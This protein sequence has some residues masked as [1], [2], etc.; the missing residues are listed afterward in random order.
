M[1]WLANRQRYT[2]TV[3]DTDGN[4]GTVVFRVLNAADHSA[5][6]DALA[7]GPDEEGNPAMRGMGRVERLTVEAAVQ[8]WD[9]TE[10]GAPLAVTEEILGLLDVRVYT[11]LVYY[12]QVFGDPPKQAAPP[13]RPAP[14]V[15]DVEE[16]PEDSQPTRPVSNGRGNTK[17][18]KEVVAS[19][20]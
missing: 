10:D 7:T 18:A 14:P 8:S 15:E 20:S 13:T 17:R 1:S 16:D 3:W 19:N 6:Q 2:R 9:F 4:P 11:Q 5:I 12:A